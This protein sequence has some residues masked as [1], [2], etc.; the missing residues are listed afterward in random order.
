[1]APSLPLL[2][3]VVPRFTVIKQR[4]WAS[5]DLYESRVQISFIGPNGGRQLC[6]RA[7]ELVYRA[8]WGSTEIIS[9]HIPTSTKYERVVWLR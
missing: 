5:K 2:Q 3:L 1:M 4:F 9:V 8:L 6:L 7:E